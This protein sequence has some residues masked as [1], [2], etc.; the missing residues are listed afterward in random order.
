MSLA[1]ALAT[2][3]SGLRASQSGLALVASNVANAQ[4]PGYIR[5][6]AVQ[7]STAAGDLGGSVRIVA[8]YREL[9]QYIQR[10]LQTETSGG[11]YAD[12]R[13]QFY[14]RLQQVYGDPGSSTTLETTF[15]NFTTAVHALGTTPESASA[16]NDVLSAGQVLAQ[17]LN[18]MTHDIQGLRTDTELGL[19]DAVTKANDAM[20]QIA[21]INRQL[22][23]TDAN[24]ST[25][26]S[27]LD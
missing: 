15:N 8:I 4:T 3:V 20:Q 27:L 16:R 11:S 19:S 23:T 14:S 7:V 17:Q 21:R 6:T 10:Q 12:L 13:A 2:A 9:D 5:K 18:S 24:D 26:A 1:Q 25:S 22:G